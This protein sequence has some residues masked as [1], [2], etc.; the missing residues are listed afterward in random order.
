MVNFSLEHGNSDGSCVAYVHLGWLVGPRFGDYRAAFRF[1]KLG[2]DLVE[3]R[4]L[5]RFKA[6]VS[7]SFGYF[8]IP[9]SRHLR[10]GVELLRRS[11]TAAQ[12]AGDFKYAV[13]SFDRLVTFLLATGDP[14]PEVQQEAEKG[15]E[16]ARA[17]KFD[18]IAD[19][20]VGQLSLIRTLRGLTPS[21]A[22]FNDPEF[23]E[24][25]FEQ[26]LEA[27]PHLVFATCW[28]WIRKLQGR[29]FAGAYSAALAAAAKAMPLVQM[30]PGFFESVEYVF[31]DALT[32]TVQYDPASSGDWIRYREVLDAEHKQLGFWAKNCPENFANRAALVGA[33]IARIE[34]R[35]LDAQRLYEQAIQSAR[36]NDFPQNEGLANELA[37][38][39]Y[40]ARG[41]ETSAYAYL[42]NARY[43]YLRWGALGKVRQ[44][45]QRYPH[46]R[47]ER[48]P[49]SSTATIGTPA[50]QLDLETVIKASHAVSGEIVLE[51][52]IETLLVIAV[53]HAGA[54]RGILI[55]PH[56]EEYW[57][58]A[59]ART[60]RQK[61][62]VQLKQAFVTPAALPESL[63]RYV[64]R[65]L[66]SVILDDA[67]VQNQFSENEYVRQRRPRSILCL[68]LV[69]Q[70]KLMGVLYLENNL[71][72]RVFT[73][74]R[75]AM[76]ELVASQAAISLEH[77]QHA[78]HL[79][80]ANEAL[81]DCLDRLASAP[82][83]DDFLGQVMTVIT[84]HLGAVASMLR[85]LNL[86]QSALTLELLVQDGRVML[87]DE[88][89][90]PE[91]WRSLSLDQQRLATLDRPTTVIH[92]SDP[93]ESM[94]EALRLYLRGLGIK[95]LLIIP[96]TLVGQTNGQLSFRFTEERD[97]D[98]E[99]LE[100]ARA[101][102]IQ[103]SLAIQLTRL[104]KTSITSAQ[105]AEENLKLA[106]E[107]A[108]GTTRAKSEFLAQMSHEIRTPMNGVIGMT[109]LLLDSDLSQQQREFADTI[110]SSA[111]TLLSIINDILD[112][113]KIEAGKMTMETVNFDLVKTIES[114]LDI[115]AARAFDKG[116]E[117]VSY[118]LPDI[119]TRLRGDPGRL[120]QI[121]TNL[122]GNAIKFTDTGE[123]VVRVTKESESETD[124]V[125]KFYVRDTGIGITPEAQAR[126]FVPFSQA[127]HSTTRKYGGSG[128]GLT[129]AKRLVEMMQGKIGVQSQ[130]GEGS[131]FWFT[132][133]FEKTMANA[134]VLMGKAAPCESVPDSDRPGAP[135]NDSRFNRQ[136]EDARILLA[137]DNYI[138]QRVA[139]G[140]LQKFGY[141]ADIVTNGLEVLEAL[142]SIPYDIILMDC[143]MPE[144]DGFEVTRAIRLQ[145]QSPGSNWKSPVHIIALTASAVQGDRERCLAAGMDDYLS[146]PIRQQELQAVLERW[147][148]TTQNR[149]HPITASGP[150]AE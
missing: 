46:L 122:V 70:A 57:I 47:E 134:T 81:R 26:H 146:K 67:S 148:T 78:D 45:D 79:T 137:E 56:G 29:F 31:Y 40:L 149:R 140:Q 20:I 86:D 52:L 88:A 144:M 101:L 117:L 110:R 59:E 17:A 119:P 21:F 12:E 107:A 61:V 6:R 5:E 24:E 13:Y 127:D 8:V 85:V 83:L 123:V 115:V 27:D 147:K 126:L 19:I 50:E 95:T 106:K 77:A 62:E 114:T 84:R 111:E 89:K 43:C 102:A 124:T 96:L 71:A 32:R 143:Q 74:T 125:L 60:G 109:G 58:A 130:F 49:A 3:K 48:A 39:F 118:I 16:F 73:P 53:E 9:W 112:F 135:E 93:H 34:G 133:R 131:T 138:N 128:L 100:I 42:R 91:S 36:E 23:H 25:R 35:E 121:L 104:A 1:G 98:P 136:P 72:P 103:A 69:K 132:A 28:Y 30:Q 18:Y 90:Y 108:E 76:L 54:E 7:L 38:K 41:Y 66:E 64:V 113:S 150:T 129:I 97:F 120:R 63:F 51:K 44:L 92:I 82:E 33:E 15:L 80:K 2:L 22:S 10:S 11:F 145:E 116:I 87:P 105:Q 68:P 75:L 139:L 141:H 142:Q 4:G 99:E 94:A 55:L 14:L 37:A 65:S